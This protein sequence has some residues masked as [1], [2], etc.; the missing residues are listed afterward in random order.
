[1]QDIELLLKEKM[2]KVQKRSARNYYDDKYDIL[3]TNKPIEKMTENV[4]RQTRH[5]KIS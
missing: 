4:L 2:H 3:L 5:Q 1:M